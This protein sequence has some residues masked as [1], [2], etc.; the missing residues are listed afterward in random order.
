MLERYRWKLGFTQHNFLMIASLIMGQ[1]LTVRK[2]LLYLT[3]FPLQ[4]IS[5]RLHLQG[6]CNSFWLKLCWRSHLQN[7]YTHIYTYTYTYNTTNNIGEPFTS[8]V[9]GKNRKFD[10]SHAVLTGKTFKPFSIDGSWQLKQGN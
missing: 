6:T 9:A 4:C 1:G 8:K 7:K 2:L 10:P 3:Y 5:V